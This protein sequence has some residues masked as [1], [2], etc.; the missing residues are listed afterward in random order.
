M[1]VFPKY[2]SSDL[3]GL[4]DIEGTRYEI[5]GGD[6]FVS[7]Q[8]SWEHQ[9]TST[10]LLRA[11]QNWS[12]ESGLGWANQAPGLIFAEDDDVAPDLI[13][14][15]SDRI[16][17]ALDD[18]GHLRAA[19]DLVVEILSPGTTNERR[20]REFKLKLYSRQGVQ[21]YWIVDCRLRSVQVYRRGTLAL[22][23]TCTLLDDDTLRSPLLP[24]FSCPLEALWWTGKRRGRPGS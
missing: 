5:I 10:E 20:D 8:P 3:E 7:K 14:M 18:A 16:N 13:W 12:H 22:E 17:D 1:S 23:L 9:F 21:E 2:T 24:G 4:P 11:L 19:P 15:R 6:L